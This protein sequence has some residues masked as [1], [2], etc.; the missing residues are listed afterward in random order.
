M[1]VVSTLLSQ[2]STWIEVSWIEEELNTLKKKEN[3][4]I[5]L[6][7]ALELNIIIFWTLWEH[8]SVLIVTTFTLQSTKHG[9]NSF[10]YKM[11]ALKVSR[12]YKYY[13]ILLFRRSWTKAEDSQRFL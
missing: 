10:L 8:F 9:L 7:F 11:Y 1:V 2:T 3:K 5:T 12:A 4:F 6:H 13:H